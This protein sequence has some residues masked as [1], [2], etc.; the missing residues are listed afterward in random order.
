MSDSTDN[1]F[2]SSPFIPS[3]SS[4]GKM[5]RSVIYALIP[6]I[7]LYIYFFGW[8]VLVNVC[9]AVVAAL[10]FE[11]LM[12][13]MCQRPVR[14][15]LF[16]GSAIITAML[17]ALALP[18][19][20]PWW[21]PVVGS[22]FAIVVAKHLYGGLGYN[23]FNPAMAAYAVLLISFPLE[24]TL[25]SLPLDKLPQNIS[26]VD[27]LNFSFFR[28][29]PSNLNIDAITSASL[30]DHIRTEV[31]LGHSL[32]DVQSSP[33]FGHVAAAEYEWI[34]IAFLAGGLWL[35]YRKII[36]WH[37]P[38]AMLLSLFTISLICHLIDDNQFSSP[39]IHL[40]GGASI[41]GAFFIAT[42][43][44]TASTTALGRLIYGC[45]IGL[46]TFAIRTWG[47]Y[48]DGVA[49]AVLLIGLTVPLLDHYTA[50]KVYG[51][52]KGYDKD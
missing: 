13:V 41:I 34:N 11:W 15:F 17:L 20:A 48:P 39:L 49:F 10:F 42:D 50:P 29:L 51:A 27:A 28:E 45:G 9:L 40:F 3:S 36:T 33:V 22:F 21:I 14:V 19:I 2:T 7:L 6:G 43:P 1:N 37:I 32:A 23:V 35:I 8:G 47:G 26:F 5:M 44:I 12:L 31:G 38:L 16:D 25:W 4:V 24:M 46:L 30:L 18:T 52:R